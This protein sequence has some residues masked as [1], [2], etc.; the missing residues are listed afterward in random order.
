MVAITKAFSAFL[1][2]LN[3]SPPPPKAVESPE[4]STAAILK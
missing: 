1:L 2:L 4:P 3:T